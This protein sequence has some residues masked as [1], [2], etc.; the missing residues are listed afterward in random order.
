[1]RLWSVVDAAWFS[2][3]GTERRDIRPEQSRF[4]GLRVVA[5][6]RG[7]RSGN[8]R[9]FEVTINLA[10]FPEDQNKDNHDYEQQ[11]W[12]VHFCTFSSK[13]LEIPGVY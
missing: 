3:E 12:D 8:E 13:E 11:E 9:L 5:A 2:P 4:L 6:F 7:G 1:V 10:Q